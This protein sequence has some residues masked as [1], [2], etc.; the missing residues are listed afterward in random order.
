MGHK[1][2]L[3]GGGVTGATAR[4][5]FMLVVPSCA[6]LCTHVRCLGCVACVA[7]VRLCSDTHTLATCSSDSRAARRSGV[8]QVN[9]THLHAQLQ[10][11]LETL[12]IA[13]QHRQL[14]DRVPKS[15][16][17]HGAVSHVFDLYIGTLPATL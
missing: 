6:R 5:D 11:L 1:L 9:D 14:Q 10:R 17:V 13:E 3:H 15:G 4:R 7:L 2:L 16:R 8:E 12:E